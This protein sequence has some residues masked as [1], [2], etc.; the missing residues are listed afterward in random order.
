MEFFKD[1]GAGMAFLCD[2]M[3]VRV[4]TTT[5]VSAAKRMQMS[6]TVLV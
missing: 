3:M 5:G 6:T 2:A 1:F 4:L